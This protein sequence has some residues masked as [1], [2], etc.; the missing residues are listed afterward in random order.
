MIIRGARLLASYAVLKTQ[1]NCARSKRFR[2]TCVCGQ[3][4]ATLETL[5]FDNRVLKSLPLDREEQNYVRTVQGMCV[6]V[7]VVG[8]EGGGGGGGLF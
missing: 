3:G 2:V 5:K 6:C 8:G 1:N 7:C 4:M